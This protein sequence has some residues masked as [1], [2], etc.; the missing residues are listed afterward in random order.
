MSLKSNDGK[1]LASSGHLCT[2]CCGGDDCI[3]LTSYGDGSSW[4]W[5]MRGSLDSGLFQ[6]GTSYANWFL[7]WDESL[8]LWLGRSVYLIPGWESYTYIWT[9]SISTR[10]IPFGMFTPPVPPPEAPHGDGWSFTNVPFSCDS[11]C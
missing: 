9:S 4:T 7:F 11:F 3:N 10:L 5:Q 6:S 2:T 8:S 1:L